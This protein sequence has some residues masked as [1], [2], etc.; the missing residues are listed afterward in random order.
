M[1][2]IPEHVIEEVRDR[3]DIV[4][5]VGEVVQL[6]KRGKNWVGLCPFHP[7]KTPSFNVT[8][9]KQMY[10][11]FGC[12]AGG[13]VFTF[14]VEQQKMEFPEAVR[15]LGERYGVE[16]PTGGGEGPDP[17]APIHEA[18][19]LAAELWHRRLLEADDATRARAYLEQR[20]LDRETWETFLLGWAPDQ[21]ETLKDEAERHGVEERTL[22]DAG[23]AGRSE[24]TGGTYDRF[25]GRLMFPIRS[26]SGR[27]I[28]FS[29]RRLDDEEPKYLNSTD[30]PVFTKGRTLFNL[31][32][33]RPEIRRTGAAL[34]VEGNFDVVALHQAGFKNVV[35]PLGTAFTEEQARILKRY[36]ATAYLA[37][38]GDAA[39][40]RSAF[41]TG[42]VLLE[43]GFAVRIVDLPEGEDPDSVVASGGAGAFRERLEASRDVIEAKIEI[44]EERVDLTDVMRKRRA[45]RRLVDSVARVPDPMTRSLYVDKIATELNVPRATLEA[46]AR[47]EETRRKK[48][49][50]RA[51]GTA[52]ASKSRSAASGR[53]RRARSGFTGELR[54]P[55][56]QNE[57]YLLLHAVADPRWLEALAGTVR[58]EW[59]EVESYGRFYERLLS[60]HDERG[61]EAL[62]AL[63]TSGEADVQRVLARVEMLRGEEQWGFELSDKTFQESVQ[64]ILERALERGLLELEDARP[65]GDPLVDALKRKELRRS[66]SPDR[67]AARKPAGGAAAATE[68]EAAGEAEGA[69]PDEV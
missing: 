20:G 7:E 54:L 12:Q 29:G 19:R 4:E 1:A 48:S 17:Y 21:W 39:G 47:D 49:R 67:I 27:V 59:F 26:T 68:S 40:E 37:Y 38:D 62:E 14:L 51:G 42:D 64:R 30:T 28:A 60:L 31:D 58:P 45:I 52:G 41:K 13:N 56:H 65:T 6:K 46:S 15:A 66:L 9:E 44:V 69:D 10:Y 34:V 33:A 36:T 50:R 16:V 24:K 57:R 43:A 5:V 35:A 25:R 32:L 53:G 55:E 3:A 22:L 63:R 11:C 61:G 23:L 18:N 8:P 2:G